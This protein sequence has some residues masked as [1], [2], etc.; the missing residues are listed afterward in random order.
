MKRYI[1]VT[2][3]VRKLKWCEKR[4]WT[5]PYYNNGKWY[6][7]PSNTFISQEIPW[8]KWEWIS[9]L[10]EKLLLIIGILL[11]LTIC[12]IALFSA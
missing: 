9:F 5:E 1:P 2:E 3:Y 4:G 7:F 12:S 8:T 6:G 10:G 11:L